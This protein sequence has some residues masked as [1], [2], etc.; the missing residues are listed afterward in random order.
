M[1]PVIGFFKQWGAKKDDFCYKGQNS[2][3]SLYMY[4]VNDHQ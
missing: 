2:F 3:Y 4:N 1:Y